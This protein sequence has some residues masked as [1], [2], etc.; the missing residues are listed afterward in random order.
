MFVEIENNNIDGLIH[1]T[2]IS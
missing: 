1:I 2:D